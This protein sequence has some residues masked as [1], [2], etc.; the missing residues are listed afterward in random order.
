MATAP[1]DAE[2]AR[3]L[4]RAFGYSQHDIFVAQPAGTKGGVVELV[5][6]VAERWRLHGLAFPQPVIGQVDEH[7]HEIFT[8]VVQ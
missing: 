6:I 5:Q 1:L 4:R 8:V 7:L 3:F 2:D